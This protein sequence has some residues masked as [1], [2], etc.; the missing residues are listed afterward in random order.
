ML[1]FLLGI[2]DGGMFYLTI[3]DL[4]PEAEER[5]INSRPQ[6][7]LRSDSCLFSFSASYEVLQYFPRKHYN[8]QMI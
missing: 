4:L 6:C 1:E 8:H 5:H 2:G 7:R 3:T